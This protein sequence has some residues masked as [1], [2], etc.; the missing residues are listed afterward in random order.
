MSTHPNA[1]LM[2]VLTP[3]GLARKTLKAIVE[4]YP[5]KNSDGEFDYESVRV[6][7][8]DGI[9]EAFHCKVMEDSYD[10]DNQISAEEGDLVFHYLVTYGYGEFISWSDLEHKKTLLE[11]WAGAVSEK[12][13]CS[14]EIRVSANYW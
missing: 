11:T 6:P 2:A 1:I 5:D 7:G 8:L 3:E 13:H 12:H 14:Y 10:E 9:G 4:E